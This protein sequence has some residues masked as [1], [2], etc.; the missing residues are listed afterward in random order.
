MSNFSPYLITRTHH[1]LKFFYVIKFQSII[2]PFTLISK[3]VRSM[4]EI[5]ALVTHIPVVENSYKNSSMYANSSEYRSWPGCIAIQW[6]WSQ[7]YAHIQIN[8][9]PSLLT[10]LFQILRSQRLRGRSYNWTYTAP[11]AR[12][13]LECY[14]PL[15]INYGYNFRIKHSRILHAWHCTSAVWSRSVDV[16]YNKRCRLSARA[17][18]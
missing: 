18:Y 13:L 12:R 5:S 4:F 16:A 1:I 9:Y 3:V 17:G 6:G 10:L 7:K 2:Y 11:Y 14:S 8:V 15:W